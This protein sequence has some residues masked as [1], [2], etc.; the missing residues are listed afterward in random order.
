MVCNCVSYSEAGGV[1]L[2][3]TSPS[4]F[5]LTK[6]LIHRNY[7]DGLK[8]TARQG[9]TPIMQSWLKLGPHARVLQEHGRSQD[10]HHGS[11]EHIRPVNNHRITRTQEKGVFLSLQPRWKVTIYSVMV[12][13]IR[14]SFC[15]HVEISPPPNEDGSMLFIYW[16]PHTVYSTAHLL[17]C[18]MQLQHLRTAVV[19]ISPWHLETMVSGGERG[20]HKGDGGGKKTGDGK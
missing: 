19:G 11:T 4:P 9:I 20:R 15:S 2:C 13:C 8:Y 5:L 1:R 14:K 6:T 10:V 12:W 3:E 17:C 18:V 7:T 16:Q